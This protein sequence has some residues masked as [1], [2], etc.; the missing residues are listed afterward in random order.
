MLESVASLNARWPVS[1]LLFQLFHMTTIH[2]CGHAIE[3]HY[4]DNGQR[5]VSY[6]CDNCQE[7]GSGFVSFGDAWERAEL[8][9]LTAVT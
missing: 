1:C 5:M 8:Q 6:P 7:P 3:D 4:E 9:Q 2:S